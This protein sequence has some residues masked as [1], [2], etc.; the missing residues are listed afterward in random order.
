MPDKKKIYKALVIVM[1][2]Y[3]VKTD[4]EEKRIVRTIDSPERRQWMEKTVMWAA[5]NGKYVIIVNEQ[6]DAK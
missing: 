3:D 4:K 1:Y 5:M 6:D 2:I